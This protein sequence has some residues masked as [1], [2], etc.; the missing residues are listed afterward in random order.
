M[1]VNTFNK[2]K[3]GE[4]PP[5]LFKF[6]LLLFFKNIRYLSIHITPLM[7]SLP[8]YWLVSAAL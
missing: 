2:N 3:G 6:N 4:L 1:Q 5:P 7:S 8:P